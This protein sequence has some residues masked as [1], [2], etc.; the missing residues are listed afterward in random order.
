ME[1]FKE[2][3][4]TE[5]YKLAKMLSEAGIP[6]KFNCIYD[7]FQVLYPNET[8]RILSAVQHFFSYG[9]EKDLIEIMGLL[10]DE[11]YEID[12][13]V[14]EL[15]ADNVFKRIEKHYNNIKKE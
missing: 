11:E 7:G 9:H 13:V 8:D 15:T 2:N 10:T 3:Q 12:S 1:D 14:G 6:Y 4:Y 5:I